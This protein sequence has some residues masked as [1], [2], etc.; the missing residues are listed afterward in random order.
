[1]TL[2]GIVGQQA[3]VQI[4]QANPEGAK[5]RKL[6]KLDA[7]RRVSPGE[8]TVPLLLEHMPLRPESHLIDFGCGTGRGG[9][10]IFRTVGCRITFM[11]FVGHCLDVGVK[12]RVDA[13]TEKLSFHQVD[14]EQP[15]SIKAAFGL[16][17]DVMEH[18]PPASVESV[19]NHVLL[20]ANHV[21]FQ[22]STTEDAMGVL[23]DAPLHLSVH[24]H[25]WWREQFTKRECAIHFEK[26]LPG[27]SIFYVSAWSSVQDVQAHGKVNVEH[28]VKREQIAHNIAQGWQSVQ[29]CQAVDD[30]VM[31]LGGGWSLPDQLDRIRALRNNGVKLVTLNNAYTW[32]LE[33]GLTPS[34]TI[35]M[36]G[37]EFNHRFVKPVVDSCKYL[38]CS[39]VHPSVFEGLPHDRTYIWHDA[40]TATFDLL[41]AQYG[42]SSYFAIPGGSTV[43]LRAIPLLRMLGYQKFHLFGC[44]SCCAPDTHRHHAYRQPE[45]D[46][47]WILPVTLNNGPVYWCQPWMICQANEFHGMI[48]ELG[49]LFELEIYGDGLLKHVLE[50]AASSP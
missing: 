6:W 15:I 23:I 36:D 7:Y 32:C 46:H 19:L 48:K 41:D 47:K 34:A 9:D 30:E 18:I 13:N 37:R 42:E 35:V 24:P 12:A 29:P 10:L 1:M 14:L 45:N 27:S 39:Q 21:W 22:I 2:V 5:Y 4:G 17:A 49:H 33:Q 8:Q 40:D 3:A 28:S 11:D 26:E 44:D 16:C 20:A 25:A 43:L 31:I 50:T 38:I